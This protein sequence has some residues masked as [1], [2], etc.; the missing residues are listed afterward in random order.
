[1][2]TLINAMIRNVVAADLILDIAKCADL[3]FYGIVKIKNHV[4]NVAL[5]NGI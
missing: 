4:G 2:I 1:M 3:L 5:I